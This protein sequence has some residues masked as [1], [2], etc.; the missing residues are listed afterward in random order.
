MSPPRS[1]VSRSAR[2]GSSSTPGSVLVI[3]HVAA[4]PPGL[5]KTVLEEAGREL[6]CVRI[7]RKEPVPRSL[8]HHGGLVILG[9]P[10]SAYD[11]D[12]YP[13]LEEEQ[14]LIEAA[15][16]GGHPVLGLGLGSQ[17]L[18]AALG[19]EVVPNG[20]REIGWH[21]VHFTRSAARDP[22]WREISDDLVAFHWHGDRFEIPRNADSLAWSA[23][24]DC[25]AFR[26]GK[27]AYGVLFHLEVNERVV[28]RMTKAFQAE[29]L[30]TSQRPA[31][32]RAAASSHLPEL[33]R[34]GRE[35]FARWIGLL[36][37]R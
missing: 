8:G 3:Q 2:T 16:D 29:L 4:E 36:G 17:L 30:S 37:D 23:L 15:L 5:L 7:Y 35:F 32:I 9:G 11:T 18:A 24:T 1:P 27:S 20:R 21:A 10:M 33:E 12:R 13:F 6:D 34:V 28:D 31:D 19:A 25:Q 14:R 22:L 26:W